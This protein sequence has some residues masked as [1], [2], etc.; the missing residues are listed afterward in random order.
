[1]LYNRFLFF[2]FAGCIVAEYHA[3]GLKTF[4]PVE[5]NFHYSQARYGKKHSGDTT[6]RTAGNNAHNGNERG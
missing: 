6:E 4:Y 2:P 5:N 3:P 1:M